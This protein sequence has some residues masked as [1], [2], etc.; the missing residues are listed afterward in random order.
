[1]MAIDLPLVSV[2]LTSYNQLH[3]LERALNTLLVQTY[4]NVEIII[5]DDGSTDGSKEFIVNK[6]KEYQGKIRYH[7]QEQ[8]VGIPRNKNTGFKLA[9]GDFITYLDGDDTYY[10]EKI[11]K[12]VEVFHQHPELGVVYSN[13]DIKEYDG[14]LLKTWGDKQM[15]QGRIFKHIVLE[16]FPYRHLHRFEMFRRQVMHDLN[17]YD[18]SFSIYHDLD[19]MMR[20]SVGYLVGYADY[21]GSSYFMNPASIVSSTKSWKMSQQ[22]KEVFAKHKELFAQNQ[23]EDAYRQYLLNKEIQQLYLHPDFSLFYFLKAWTSQPS[24]LIPI[25]KA[26]YFRFRSKT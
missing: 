26:L 24:K 7:L 23:M 19:F 15:P 4:P 8:N 3:L 5:V 16:E 21:V 20:Y 22:H 25:A 11:A 12:E 6:G 1:M 18:E 13:F 14:T 9:Q 10:P 2:V 17:F